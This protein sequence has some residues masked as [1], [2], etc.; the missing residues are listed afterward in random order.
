MTSYYF[1]DAVDSRGN[2]K[3]ITF[4]SAEPLEDR[5]LEHKLME[6][7]ATRCEITPDTEGAPRLTGHDELVASHANRRAA[8]ALDIDVLADA[9]AER[10]GCSPEDVMTE[11]PGRISLTL[12]QVAALLGATS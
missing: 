1:P 6:L 2:A 4:H 11:P 8:A 5:E 12:E 7:G 9:V 3:P 10:I